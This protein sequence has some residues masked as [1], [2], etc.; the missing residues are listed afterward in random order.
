[1]PLWEGKM[2]IALKLNVRDVVT[3]EVQ[4]VMCNV[5]VTGEEPQVVCHSLFQQQ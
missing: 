3:N 5:F 2:K 4:S 1:M